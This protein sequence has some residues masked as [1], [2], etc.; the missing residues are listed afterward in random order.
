MTSSCRSKIG[1]GITNADRDDLGIFLELEHAT[2][3]L[4]H[5]GP[6]ESLVLQTNFIYMVGP[7]RTCGYLHRVPQI[8]RTIV[9]LRSPVA[10]TLAVAQL[11]RSGSI[12]LAVSGNV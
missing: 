1:R 10:R 2:R 6:G 3:L 4:N 8:P 9:S 7:T 12:A 5:P 11:Q